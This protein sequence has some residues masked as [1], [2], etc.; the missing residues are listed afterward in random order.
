MA[1]LC[2]IT[3]VD[4]IAT[5]AAFRGPQPFQVD[6]LSE[7]NG[8][9]A[10]RVSAPGRPDEYCQGTPGTVQS[11][12][13]L[14]QAG[15]LVTL[16]ALPQPDSVFIGWGYPCPDPMSPV[17]HV[18]VTDDLATI[19]A[20]RGPQPL[21]VDVFSEENG[22]GVVRVSAPGRSDEYCQG[23]PGTI[24]SCSY[25]F[26]AGTLVTLEAL[27]GPGSVFS[28]WDWEC[29]GVRQ[30]TCQ[31]T[32]THDASVA[33]EF[34]GP[35]PLS[36]AIDSLEDGV[37]VVRVSAP[38]RPEEYCEGTPG[39]IQNC[40][41]LYQPGTVVTLVA[42]P[43]PGSV[44][45][46][47]GYPCADPMSPICQVT[48]TDDLTTYVAFRGPQPLRVVIDSWENGE[49]SVRLSA[50]GRSE[51]HCEGTPGTIQNCSYLYQ[52]GTVVTL[53]ALPAPGSV[54]VGWGYPCADP[55]SPICQVTITDDLN[56]TATFR[57][58]QQL[59]VDIH[60]WDNGVGVVRVSAP[61][62]SEQ[63][64]EGTPGTV[65][66]CSYLFK[67]GTVVTLEALPG[68]D[69]VFMGWDWP[70]VPD[71]AQPT[72]QV[73]VEDE[74]K[75]RTTFRGPQQLQVE[76]HSS[77]SG[78]GVVRVSAP[79]RPAE[80]CHGTPDTIQSCR[81][82]L[83]P[84]TVVILEAVPAP[85]SGFETWEGPCADR[86]APTCPVTVT[87]N[88]VVGAAFRGPQPLQV[89]VESVDDGV[90]V[91]RLS[92]TGYPDETC[93]GTPGTTQSCT[94]LF[95]PGTVVTLTATPNPDSRFLGWGGECGGTGPCQ[96]LLM[97]DLV[98]GAAFEI[99]NHPPVAAPGGPYAGVRNEPIVFDGSG[100]SDPDGNPLTFH[101]DF[102]DGSTGTGA[103]PNHAYASL[104]MFTVTLA[105]ND[106]TAS[107]VP[108]TTTATIANRE[109]VAN[110]GPDQ[111]VEL[112]SPVVL[113]G[114]GSSDPDQD[115]ISYEWR[116]SGGNVV[117]TAA[118]VTLALP[119][120]THD[121][122][123]TAS[124]AFGGVGSDA[125]RIVVVDTSAPVVALTSPQGGTLLTGVPTT[126][127]WAAEDNG[128]IVSFDV[129]SSTDGGA[130]FAPVPGCTGLPGSERSCSW[131][132]P[133]PATAQARA[134]VVG[135]DASG[136]LGVGESA[137]AIVDPL[138]T[139][140]S[141]DARVNWGIGST[142]TIGWTHNLGVGSL[143]RIELSRDGG[144]T[145]NLIASPVPTTA[146]T[147]GSFDW[148]VTGPS[149]GS[150]RI[151][152]TF[153][154]NEAASDISD[155]DFTVAPARVKVMS[156][157]RR[158]RWTIGS[159]QAIR[160]RHNLGTSGSVRLELSRDG[161]SSWSVIAPSVPNDAAA[162][163]SFPWTV[164][165]P[166]TARARIRVTWT[167]N[168]SVSDR[169][170]VDLRID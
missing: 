39:T 53:E 166:A 29:A 86:V 91:V 125:V 115:P 18:T 5:I 130:T 152:V 4:D 23:T 129:L 118:V 159:V 60:S 67:Q 59:Q 35:Q 94:Y 75:T 139:V 56:T 146:A 116:D 16:E 8:E 38:G 143:V 112:G 6:V 76:V 127:G 153:V 43:A 42:L 119:L 12:S 99:A 98:V 65:Q 168:P 32:I 85:G 69:S 55:M 111:T 3:V 17:C 121:V 84:G 49:G 135:R 70:C 13:Y 88:V 25:L 22:L 134:R 164:T 34:R 31:V 160:W 114:S 9:G 10:V 105:V 19:A 90:G 136:N 7:E 57:G 54:F 165:G 11:C 27:P 110:A 62:Y 101:W 81:Y 151:R 33:A 132:S 89:F 63:Y 44:F 104:G 144:A 14:F 140:T 28:A 96:I 83:R 47:W 100:S 50:P 48:V 73:T 142:Q 102:G 82:L 126:I 122:T 156:P 93:E 95:K 133:G 77:E 79:D 87:E 109:P 20:F 155:D 40:S 51:E 123:L 30:P 162:T 15:T 37:G 68:P 26:Q 108:V 154:A 61:G 147:A 52:S 163:G 45:V 72:C 107:S 24:Q 137:F 161:G 58:P 169:S 64:C 113:N 167:A 157:N 2:Q 66:S 97:D 158:V 138:V 120:G 78:T 128:T 124:D 92:A 141:P 36:I 1:S 150:A 46:G 117:G 131:S 41:Y 74:L 103:T 148:V 145:W 21:Q 106:G 80:Y 170:D 149:S 71:P